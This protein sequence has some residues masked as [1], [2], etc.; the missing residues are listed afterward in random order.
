MANMTPEEQK[1]LFKEALQEWLDA[2]YAE[3]G[4]WTVRGIMAAFLVAIV[5]F[6]TSHGVKLQDFMGR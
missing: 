6:L 2:R 4:Q 5:I 1:A 3:F